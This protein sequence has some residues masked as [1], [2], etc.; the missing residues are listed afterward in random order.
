MT[1]T[2]NGTVRIERLQRPALAYF[3]S[4]IQ[5][6]FAGWQHHKSSKWM[7]LCARSGVRLRAALYPM[8]QRHV[9]SRPLS[10]RPLR[11]QPFVEH[12]LLSLQ[13]QL[14]N[15]LG[16]NPTWQALSPFVSSAS[17]PRFVTSGQVMRR[18]ARTI[19][20]LPRS[21]EKLAAR[22]SGFL[23]E[24]FSRHSFLDLQNDCLLTCVNGTS[25]LCLSEM[26]ML[27]FTGAV[28]QVLWAC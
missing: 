19:A 20:S 4:D 23:L 22:H 26:S 24:H 9:N 16:V 11:L 14:G 27:A 13:P 25:T 15:G 5:G 21:Q 8:I 17:E 10:H 1:L 28:P 18:M 6:W 12:I 7:R 2:T 3:I